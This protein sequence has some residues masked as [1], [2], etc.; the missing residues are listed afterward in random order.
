MHSSILATDN[1]GQHDSGR[2]DEPRL[3]ARQSKAVLLDVQSTCVA[4]STTLS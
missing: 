4:A 2:V 3:P 1:V